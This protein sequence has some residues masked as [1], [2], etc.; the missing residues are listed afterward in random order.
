MFQWLYERCSQTVKK[1][2]LELGGNAAFIVFESADLEKAVQACAD[3]KF[4]NGGQTCICANRILVQDSIYDQFCQKLEEK[5][6][7]I[8]MGPP[9][10]SKNSQGPLINKRAVEKVS[11]HV[12][13]AIARGGVLKIGGKV[14]RSLGPLYFEPTLITEVP[15]DA[16]VHRE[17]TFGPLA[18]ITR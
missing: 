11:R 18:A 3:S 2:S 8:K 15:S 12:D 4:R 10:N 16:L 7:N 6:K 14:D 13:D 1:L 9:I 5:V 17:E